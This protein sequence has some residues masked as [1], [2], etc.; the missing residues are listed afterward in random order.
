M[1]KKKLLLILPISFFLCSCNLADVGIG[2][3]KPFSSEF[4][5]GLSIF[6]WQPFGGKDNKEGTHND[7]PIED[8]DIDE[9]KHATSIS[10]DPSAAFYLKKGE[11]R[12]VKVTLSPST[13]VRDEEKTFTWS[14]TKG[15]GVT[16][17]SG[18]TGNTIEIT[19]VKASN[20]N[21]VTAVND[22]NHSLTKSFTIHVIDFDEENDYL[23]QYD[24]EDKNQFGYTS[25]H[26]QGDASGVAT[27]NGISWSFLREPEAISINTTQSGAIGFGKGENPETHVHFEAEVGRTVESITF[28]VASA[29]SLA[30]MSV[31]VGETAYMTEKTVPKVTNNALNFLTTNEVS[32]PVSGK[33]QIDVVTPEMDNSRKE[34]PDYNAPGAF[35]LKS[36]LIHFGGE[37]EPV[38][39]QTFNFKEMYDNRVAGDGYFGN[40]TTTAKTVE[41]SQN[42]FDVTL[43][44]VKSESNSDDEKIPGYAHTNGYIDIK[45]NKANEEFYKV[46]FKINYGTYAE[47]SKTIYALHVSKSGG[48]PFAPTGLTSTIDEATGLLN[49]S[50]FTNAHYNTIRLKPT[51]ENNVSNVGL[52]YLKVTT[53]AGINPTIASIST[54][55]LFEPSVT[56]YYDGDLFNTEGL[57]DLIIT[58]EESGVEPDALPASEL[59]WFDGA[60]Y[61]ENPATATKVLKAGTKKVYG[62]FRGEVVATI[63]NITVIGEYE[64]L[65]L[66]KSASDIE[67]NYKYLIV[68]QYNSGFT[69]LNGAETGS[70]KIMDGYALNDFVLDDSVQVSKTM[71]SRAFTASFD[72]NSKLNFE[73]SNHNTLGL[74][75]KGALS[76]TTDSKILGWD[77]EV[78]SEN[79]LVMTM[80]DGEDTPV[81]KE[82][83]VNKTSG[84]YSA[85]APGSS[86]R[87]SIYLFKF[88]D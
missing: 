56:E 30:K 49:V 74:T 9:N 42:D 8:V 37:I 86:S 32:T 27:L 28:E 78:T 16:I 43:E 36:I 75:T 87:G 22:Y 80:Y 31:S 67:A 4:W 71:L 7:T 14:I 1:K 38:T 39:V 11:S 53:K 18:V 55:A 68:G 63:E 88:S 23:W 58:Y 73:N 77:Y 33:I 6:G 41:F 60:S 44:K 62:V 13:G 48:A 84:K 69:C 2:Q 34:D 51:K 85:Y 66:V 52:D 24:S 3:F 82:F 21:V 57:N 50:L 76:C 61:D 29:N 17:P 47:S 20:G 59:E 83:G 72:S 81:Q 26:K 5:Q 45:L 40:L 35:Y 46:E 19:A 12:T 64:T 10:A 15:D 25:S 79:K 65:T 54:P 70:G